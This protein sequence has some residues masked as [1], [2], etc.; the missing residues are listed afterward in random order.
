MAWKYPTTIPHRHPAL[1]SR[2]AGSCWLPVLILVLIPLWIM[3]RRLRCVPGQA[4]AHTAVIAG[5]APVCY[6]FDSWYVFDSIALPFP[7]RE[8]RGQ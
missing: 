2:L 4:A 7:P 6:T 3:A 1:L 8:H 5:N